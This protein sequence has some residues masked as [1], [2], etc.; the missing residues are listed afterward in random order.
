MSLLCLPLIAAAT[1]DEPRT[2]EEV[3]SRYLSA[4]GA[5]R[6]ASITTFEKRGE[7]YG[8][9]GNLLVGK[10]HGTFEFYFKSPNLRYGWSL[11][12]KNL[13]LSLRGCDGK[14][15]WQFDSLMRLS[16][17]KPKPGN[18]Y[19]CE[20]GLT[21]DPARL[22]R[23]HLKM[24][25][26]K[27][28]EMQ[29]HTVWEVKVEDPKSSGTEHY[30]FDADTFLLFR[31]SWGILNT[32]YSDY[33]AVDGMMIPFTTV[34][35]YGDFISSKVVST[36]RELKI[37]APIDDARFVEPHPKNGKVDLGPSPT[38]KNPDA[39]VKTADT[40]VKSPET[41][42][43]TVEVPSETN[44]SAVAVVTNYD[45]ATKVNFPNFTSCSIE[46]LQMTVPDLKGLKAEADQGEL[47]GLLDK[48]G[49][50]TVDVARHTPNLI[51][52]ENVTESGKGVPKVQH[53]YDYLIVRRLQRNAVNLN[54]YRV[55]VKTGD[56]FQ[57]DSMIKDDAA[58]WKELEG[59]SQ[60]LAFKSGGPPAS[61]GFATAWVYFYPNN[62]QQA[63]FRYLGTQKL[64]G[65]H[66]LVVAF[67]QKPELVNLPGVF[68]YQGHVALMF[69][70]GVAWIDPSDFRIL[71]LRTDL[72]AP[73]PEV[74]LHRLTADIEFAATEVEDVQS[75]LW[76]PREV[77][78]TSECGGLT[79]HEVHTYSRYR[80]FRAKSKIVLNP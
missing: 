79:L 32:T 2:A 53:K 26:T 25:L 21:L 19:E 36:V 62:R 1:E 69:L 38:G 48:I 58:A 44:A 22:Q 33:R 12:A 64:N 55:D 57:T 72:L 73:V 31:R 18:E 80:L 56:K 45:S 3:T 5:E 76:L 77:A 68:R 50:T 34:D 46:E 52:D 27:K 9:L 41:P 70:Q 61:Q 4:I 71:R 47:A 23:A 14:V 13:V 40:S 24:R 17:F 43:K 67:A 15:S 10:E 37:N 11:S 54:E 51:S 78:V 49:A 28:K 29:G 8:D 60:E 75:P 16:E 66:T 65:K 59:A 30:Y 74:S 35:D 42:A 7:L 6:F 63:A 39:A 20:N